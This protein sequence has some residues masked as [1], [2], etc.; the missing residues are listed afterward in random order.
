MQATILTA[1]II[2][3]VSADPAM[4]R[5]HS[6]PARAAFGDVGTYSLGG[7]LAL[8]QQ[9]YQHQDFGS[10]QFVTA[11]LAPEVDYFVAPNLA[12]HVR[13]QAWFQGGEGLSGFGFGPGLGI[14]YHAPLAE[15]FGIFPKVMTVYRYNRSRSAVDNVSGADSDYTTHTIDVAVELPLVARFGQLFVGVG[16]RFRKQVF[17]RGRYDGQAESFATSRFTTFEFSTRV[18]GWFD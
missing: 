15:S 13:G 9:T 5:A 4:S 7:S 8:A 18:G 17:G 2:A 12:V 3:T 14:G 16:P 11:S 10:S 6:R 1:V